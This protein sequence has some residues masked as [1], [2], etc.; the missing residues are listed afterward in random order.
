[1]VVGNFLWLHL[2]DYSSGGMEILEVR[3]FDIERHSS[4]MVPP[5]INR[6]LLPSTGENEIQRKVTTIRHFVPDEPP[7]KSAG[8]YF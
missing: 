1:M 2:D 3:S 7:P 5:L 6:S 8:T 4:S